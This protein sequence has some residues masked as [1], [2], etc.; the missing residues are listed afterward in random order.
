MAIQ[1]PTMI[2]VS[3]WKAT[4]KL[5][6]LEEKRNDIIRK[7]ATEWLKIAKI[8]PANNLW[9]IGIPQALFDTLEGYSFDVADAAAI[10]FLEYRGYVITKPEEPDQ[11]AG[12]QNAGLAGIQNAGLAGIQNI[13]LN[14]GPDYKKP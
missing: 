2:R 12:I 10:A 13:N 9:P 5:Y 6:T 14:Q 1:K 8:N 7:C 11:L 4:E 3:R